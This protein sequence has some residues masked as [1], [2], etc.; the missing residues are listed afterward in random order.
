MLA[1]LL[2]GDAAPQPSDAP[3]SPTWSER[4]ARALW[5]PQALGLDQPLPME[6]RATFLPAMR[7][8]GSDHAQLALPGILA[9]MVNAFTLPSR[10]AGGTGPQ[11]PEE[12]VAEALNFA[13]NVSLDSYALSR[14]LRTPLTEQ[15]SMT[16]G[17]AT[18]IAPPEKGSPD[19]VY[20]GV[21]SDEFNSIGKTGEIKST[22]RYSHSSEG[23]SFSDHPDIAQSTVTFGTDDPARTGKPT[24][25]LEVKR[26]PDIVRDPRDGWPKSTID[27]YGNRTGIPA[28]RIARVWKFNP[29]GSIELVPPPAA[30]GSK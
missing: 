10:A 3:S 22:G 8:P 21:T 30:S 12:K 6:G 27:P 18:N 20:R 9:G 5:N 15:P 14:I 29:D 25:V 11:T 24:Y 1:Q 26:G 4:L 28:D 7:P 13:G 23:T 2:R 17:M 16:A 19:M